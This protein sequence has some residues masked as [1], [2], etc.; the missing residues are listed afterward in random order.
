MPPV[1]ITQLQ[2][3]VAGDGLKRDYVSSA[4]ISSAVKLAA[5]ASEDQLFPEH[6]GFDWKAIEKSMDPA[7]G[8]RKKKRALGAAAS[9]IS[10]QTAKNIFLWQGSGWTRYVR[11]VPEMFYTKMIEWVWG[12]QRIMEVYLNTIEMGRGIYGI[13]AAAQTY[14][15]KPAATLTPAES[16]KIV[17]CLPNPKVFTVVPISKRVAWRYPQILRQMN[18]LEGDPVVAEII[19]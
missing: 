2:S 18:N 10:Q 11:K 19:H 17:A 4:Q 7:S 1:T 6:G 13:E 16:A 12:K 9:T 14:F 5:I 8:R 3:L 15:H